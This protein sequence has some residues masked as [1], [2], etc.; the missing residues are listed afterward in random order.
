MPSSPSAA[1]VS[2]QISAL[3]HPTAVQ[4]RKKLKPAIAN[5]NLEC[6]VNNDA[7]FTNKRNRYLSIPGGS[8]IDCGA[9][10]NAYTGRIEY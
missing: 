3:N 6:R 4:P 10:S 9:Y 1:V 5:R 7:Y 2:A 8:S